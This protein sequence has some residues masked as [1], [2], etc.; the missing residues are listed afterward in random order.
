MMVMCINPRIH[1]GSPPLQILPRVTRIC[2]QDTRELD[3]ELNG[4]VL[5]EDPVDAVLVVCGRE[6]LADEELAGAGDGAGVVAEVGVLEEDA[7]VFFVEADC[8]FYCRGAAVAVYEFGVCF[9][10]C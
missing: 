8:V 4:A 9:G 6:D 2:V 7:G 5:V 3:L 1:L 10:R